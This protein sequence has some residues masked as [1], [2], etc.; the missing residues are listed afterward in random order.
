MN[1]KPSA[2]KRT[3]RKGEPSAAGVPQDLPGFSIPAPEAAV[4]VLRPVGH[5]CFD[6]RL[7]DCLAGMA[8]LPAD[9]VDVVVT[10][11]P[12]NLDIAYKS[13]RDDAPREAY[14]DWCECWCSEVR[15]VLKP[16]GSFFLNVGAA[17]AN[18]WFPHEIAL[19]LRRLF[20]LQNTLHWVKSITVQPKGGEEISAGHF[21]PL[22]GARFLNDCH[23]YIFHFTK[24]GTVKLDRTGVGVAYVYKSN[25]ARWGHTE[26]K[27]KRCRGNNWFIPYKTIMSRD[28][29]RPHP[30]TFPAQLAEWCIRLHG[31]RDG[32]TVLD[33]FLG[34]GHAAEGARVC[35]VS[36]FIGFEID[37]GYLGEACKRLGVP[38]PKAR[39]AD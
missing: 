13:Y 28:S 3:R 15:R 37:A 10:S 33:P 22:Q 31:Q 36:T 5:T 30:A 25:I 35:G 17:P 7:G 8:A 18:P 38:V 21:K 27:D 6:F 29:E 32:L 23:E 1:P 4:P 26:G 9:S 39:R 14:L 34:I 24:E 11:P 16:D 19:R 2:A 12:Y 20:S